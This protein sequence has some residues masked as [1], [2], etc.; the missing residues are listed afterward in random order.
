MVG[1]SQSLSFSSDFLLELVNRVLS[2]TEL[3]LE[4]I[5]LVLCFNQVL[6]VKVA[7]RPNSFIQILL[8][9]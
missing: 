1:S 3:S 6:G 8:C 7:L 5:D 4:L 9:F 2:D